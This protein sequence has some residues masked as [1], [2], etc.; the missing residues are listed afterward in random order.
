M[1]IFQDTREL[2]KQD[3]YVGMN[4]VKGF[5]KT[6]MAALGYKDTGE[7]NA[8]GQAMSVLNPLGD[9]TYGR[10]GANVLSKGTDTNEVIKDTNSEYYKQKYDQFKF[11]GEVAKTVMTFGKGGG[12]EGNMLKS[13]MGGDGASNLAASGIGEGMAGEIGA[14]AVEEGLNNQADSIID[15]KTDFELIDSLDDDEEEL[16][17]LSD[18]L[19]TDESGNEYYVSEDGKR[20]YS[21]DLIEAEKQKRGTTNQEKVNNEMSRAKKVANFGKDIPVIGGIV[22]SGANLYASSRNFANEE[23]REIEKYKYKTAKDPGFN[24]L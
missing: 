4:K 6:A 15:N 22:S 16:D 8:W 2:S 21:S 13:V 5:K 11:A 10:L 14:D 23:D 7:R 24:L 17:D 20:V 1:A 3:R 18:W 9:M 12:G 19:K